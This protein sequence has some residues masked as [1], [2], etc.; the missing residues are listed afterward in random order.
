MDLLGAAAGLI[1]LSPALLLIAF[2]IRLDSPGPILFRQQRPGRSLRSFTVLKFRSMVVGSDRIKPDEF[3]SLG[4]GPQQKTKAD[5]RITRV[6]RVLRRFSL[7][8]LPQLVN[9]LR[10]EMS[11]VGPRPL[12]GWEL[13]QSDLMARSSVLPGLTGL[14]QVSGRSELSFEEML[15][16]DLEYVSNRS[17]LMDLTIV[18]RTIPAM[19]SRR[20][21]Y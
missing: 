12:L 8:E 5:P 13:S 11:L 15:R 14:W 19:F 9:V 7:D 18:L 16:L 2:L 6:G 20:G 4:Y 21:A 17:L 10:G 1:L 3:A